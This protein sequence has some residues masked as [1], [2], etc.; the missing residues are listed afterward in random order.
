MKKIAVFC[1]SSTGFSAIYKNE[2]KR[3]G[4]YFAKNDISLVYGGGKIGLMGVI[5]D[6]VIENS[7]KV[8]GV[9]PHLLKHE[10][11]IHQGTT[12][13]ILTKTMSERKI[14][15]SKMVDGYIALAGGF[16]TLDEIFEVLTL[17]QL[18]IES[19]P[20]GLLNINGFFNP[21]INQ[22]DIM[23]KE[24][25]LKHSNKEMLLVDNNIE[26][27]IDKMANYK[28]INNEKVIHKIASK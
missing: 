26:K 11:V 12:E 15:M 10:E 16:G 5:A 6:S 17:G 3:L 18:S 21:L 27:L 4:I 9:I 19:K 24:G 13:M 22:L 25:F 7:G 8:F 20:I 2:A 23:V 28:A 14:L 1:G